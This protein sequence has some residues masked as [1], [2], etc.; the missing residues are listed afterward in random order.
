MP[1]KKKQRSKRPTIKKRSA[2]KL[3]RRQRIAGKSAVAVPADN[4]NPSEVRDDQF[5]YAYRKSEGYPEHS[6][7]LGGKWLLFVQLPA[8]D[9]E[10]QTIRQ[11][12][13]EGK[14]G[15]ISKVAT[16]RPSPLTTNAGTKVICV[17]TYDWT[18]E[19]DV[20]RVRE[21]LRQLGFTKKIPYKADQ[22][23]REGQY[24]ASATGRVSKYYE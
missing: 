15:G 16:A 3:R 19:A 11:A 13:E 7:T 17:Y 5:I 2:G 21:S 1:K 9:A 18:D 12:T 22:E 10:W 23:T 20:R 8:L 4:R 24:A 6:R 14:L